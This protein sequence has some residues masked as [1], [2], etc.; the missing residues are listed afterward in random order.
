M[1][2]KIEGEKALI[3]SSTRD[4]SFFSTISIRIVDEKAVIPSSTQN[5]FIY[6]RHERA[7]AFI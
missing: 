3:P 5:Q 7:V 4:E 1:L 6:F 2:L